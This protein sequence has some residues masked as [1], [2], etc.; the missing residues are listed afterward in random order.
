MK[1]HLS[2]FSVGV[3]KS[4]EGICISIS[5]LWLWR[6]LYTFVDDRHGQTSFALYR[7]HSIAIVCRVLPLHVALQSNSFFSICKS[8]CPLHIEF[9]TGRTTYN[10]NLTT[11]VQIA[12]SCS[13]CTDHIHRKAWTGRSE[14]TAGRFQISVSL[15][16]IQESFIAFPPFPNIRTV[17][18]Q[19][20]AYVQSSQRRLLYHLLCW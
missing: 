7:T 4:V 1:Y 10:S 17:V 15:S 2:Q 18:T 13:C 9:A 8:L 12:C 20:Q 5:H 19:Q 16:N 14:M 6:L 11:P 3:S